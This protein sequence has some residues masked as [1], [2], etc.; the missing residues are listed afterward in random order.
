MNQFVH[1]FASG[2]VTGG[3]YGSVALALV[4]IYR[5][6]HH[7][8]FAQGEMAMFTTYVCWELIHVGMPY[9]A[10]FATTVIFG[11]LFGAA[12]ERV[13]IRPVE[14]APPL[15]AVIVSL[16][17]YVII[18]SLAGFF[19]TSTVRDFPSPFPAEP[20]IARGLISNH[21]L[22]SIAV[23]LIELAM[24]YAFFRFSSLGLIMRAAAENPSSSRLVGI[25]VGRM[26][27]LGWGLAAAI[28]AVAGMMIAPTL[29]LDP[30]LMSGVLLYGLTAALL[31][32]IDNPWGAV[33]GGFIVG[34]IENLLGAYV[35]STQLKLTVA[36]VIIVATL[37]VRPAGLF[38]RTYVAR[39]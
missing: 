19:F 6:T 23:T 17:V 1:Q 16:G 5:A 37:V 20:S 34:V 10:A 3:I 9:W 24:V 18:N 29:F 25:R 39:V 31:G 38:G 35:V 4:M 30:T 11:F 33:L 7:V 21:E 22:G 2:L 15:T 28:G 26:L 32:G 36:L 14:D 8:N 12:I 13:V 27:A